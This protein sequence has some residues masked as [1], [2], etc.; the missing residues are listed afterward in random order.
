MR[1][2]GS[3]LAAADEP[4]SD[5]FGVR[6]P[7]LPGPVDEFG[8]F[9][10]QEATRPTTALVAL[11]GIGAASRIARLGFRGSGA[12]AGFVAP[13]GGSTLA[14]KMAAETAG[15]AGARAGFGFL[16]EKFEDA[17]TSAR[18]ALG[19]LGGLVGGAGAVSGL[20][21]GVRTALRKDIL[22]PQVF[23]PTL[24]PTRKESG[25]RI[26]LMLKA[27]TVEQIEAGTG[28]PATGADVVD[29]GK[30]MRDPSIGVVQQQTEVLVARTSHALDT[31]PKLT[32]DKTNNLVFTGIRRL[33]PEVPEP[34]YVQEVLEFG[35][36]RFDLTPAQQRAVDDIIEVYESLRTERGLFNVEVVDTKLAKDQRFVHRNQPERGPGAPGAGG[37]DLRRFNEHH[38][39]FTDPLIA[40]RKGEGKIVYGHPLQAVEEF[41]RLTLTDSA[42]SHIIGLLKTVLGETPG[43]RIAKDVGTLLM[44]MMRKLYSRGRTLQSRAGSARQRKLEVDRLEREMNESLN[45]LTAR[46]EALNA[47]EAEAPDIADLTTLIRAARE[48]ADD[49]RRLAKK[50][51]ATVELLKQGKRKLTGA[52]KRLLARAEELEK[53]SRAFDKIIDKLPSPTEGAI[54]TDKLLPGEE[55]VMQRASRTRKQAQK[56]AMKPMRAIERQM[57][58]I[59]RE[60]VNLDQRVESLLQQ[61]GI[62]EDLGVEAKAAFSESLTEITES[63]K[64]NMRLR[65]AEMEVRAARIDES[66][67]ASRLQK[68]R[69]R[70]GEQLGRVTSTKTEIDTLK[71]DIDKVRAEWDEIK[72]QAAI[73]PEG[74]RRLQGQVAPSLQNVDFP[75]EDIK[76]IQRWM[77]EGKVPDT[78]QGRATKKI[79]GINRL[80]VPVRSTFDFSSTLNQLAAFFSGNPSR[81]VKNLGWAL[82]DSVNF[83]RYDKYLA[84]HGQEAAADGV[85]IMGRGRNTSSDFE[86]NTWFERVPVLGKVMAPFQRH[87]Q[88]FTTRMRV[89]VYNDLVAANLAKGVELDSLARNEIAKGLNRM[90][91]IATSR[92][93]DAET[94]LEFAPNFVRS[95]FETYWNGLVN[96][97]IDGQLARHYMRNMTTFAVATAAGY[98]LA[99]G[100]EPSEV[101]K[102]ISTNALANGEIRLNPNFLTIRVPGIDQ[103]VS[104]MGRFDSLAR[105][106]VLAGDTG[107][108]VISERSVAPLVEGID[109]LARSKGSPTLSTGWNLVTGTTFTGE[110]PLSPTGFLSEILPFS[111]AAFIQDTE[112]GYLAAAGGASVNAL[113]VKSNPITPFE[114]LQQEA[115]VMF[116]K[117][118]DT[119][120]GQERAAL[121]EAHPAI[122]RRFASQNESFARKGDEKALAR[123]ENEQID[124][125]RLTEEGNLSL[126]LQ[127]GEITARQYSE[128][129]DELQHDSAILKQK[130]YE[131]LDV[132]FLGPRS[133][134]GRA[135]SAWYATFD[136]AKLGG[137]DIIDFDLREQLEAT[138]LTRIDAGEFGDAATARRFIDERSRPLH[139]DPLAQRYFAAKDVLSQSE[140][141][142]IR[143]SV[144]ARRG[145]AATALDPTITRYGDLLTAVDV[146]ERSGDR[147]RAARLGRILRA[148]DSEVTRQRDRLIRTN[149]TLAEALVIT[150]RRSA[151]SPAVRA[152]LRRR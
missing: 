47:I 140:Y 152:A 52:D 125:D 134:P 27:K 2:A 121:E 80:I 119:L 32:T 108:G 69:L 87:F 145:R 110:D 95:G 82:R 75:E 122:A 117:P 129:L 37:Q 106:I 133:A 59:I 25:E 1:T 136:E 58:T 131:V 14:T 46:D 62:L 142:S 23:G 29:E 19:L 141:Y 79:R 90:S 98:A 138:L 16:D 104:L 56:K 127:A 66:R 44:G 111:M 89:D 3:V 126:A 64:L 130:V 10:L 53:S 151:S 124:T 4:L 139:S 11:G 74:R 55:W 61:R 86:F 34:A 43:D 12:I 38:R 112:A 84:T 114:R 26:G 13:V 20:R 21:R 51:G 41:S 91:G 7:D 36:S 9:I 40:I 101:L 109:F 116:Q 33:N 150:G 45:R 78:Q 97:D 30:R 35:G 77:D 107:R 22:A 42:T 48:S 70:Q 83:K 94:L 113:G 63:V 147:V 123:I 128:R 67:A 149:P 49:A 93:G 115:Q 57:D 68:G 18:I 50:M 135:L 71:Q 54:R 143:D 73:V 17:P 105:L 96:G 81:F 39:K 148:V 118:L 15:A 103:D 5:R 99:T 8:N 60:S 132:D 120:T 6:I 72:R 137:T 31:L 65:T 100:R 92:A 76:A 144:F 24:R 88:S 28:R 85:I 146:A 102:P